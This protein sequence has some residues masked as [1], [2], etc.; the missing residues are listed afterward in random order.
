MSN[1]KQQGVKAFTWDF[2]GKLLSQGMGFIVTIFLARLLEPEDFGLVA[3]IMV[4]IGIANIFTDIGLGGALIQRRRVHPIHYSSVFYFNIIVGF[5][6][7][8]VTYL[9]AEWIGEF[10]QN[11]QLVVLVQVLS[12]LF[13]INA[14]SS[15]QNTRLR[16]E[17]NYSRLTKMSFISSLISGFVGIYLAMDGA[18][19]WSLVG[20][21]LTMTVVYNVL[22]WTITDWRPSLRFSWKAL[23][24]L[25][26]YG[27]RMFLSGM[28]DV[29]F[30]KI[31]FLIIGK[32]FPLAT[33]GYFQRAKSLNR[34][35]VQ[36]SSGSLMAVLFPVFSK[37]QNDVPRFQNII[38]KSL[39]IISFV[40]F[41]LI[42]VLFLISEELIVI[43][44]SAKWLPS[45][46]FFKVLV[47]SGFAYPISAL[48]VNILS[49]RGKSKEFLRLEIYKKL[50]ASCNLLILFFLG[51]NAF[52]YG[53]IVQGVLG[54]LL[55]IVFASREI[56]LQYKV[57]I[58]P[59]LVQL[60]ISVLAV[61]LTISIV[62]NL[63][64][65]SLF[66]L[67]IK[68]S[69]FTVLYFLL[70]YLMKTTSYG[71]FMGELKSIFSER[72]KYQKEN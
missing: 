67:L 23:R 61:I 21:I 46:D 33:L 13:V 65:I 63:E 60:S 29:I 24:Q 55:N 70:S 14:L 51:I 22:I 48:L 2:F 20:Q 6:L 26:G 5:F 3:L 69:V 11:K 47:L 25:W 1:L 9:S 44:F 28:L 32:I 57:F 10:Y 64:L 52:L 72:V 66:M 54:V 71:Y 27:F 40:V 58:K 68:G 31:D 53:L 42:G 16:K 62:D 12:S 50:I 37:V 49:S 35:V 34:M 59:I 36:Y 19:V 39:G 45:V 4:I 17:L 30:T 15:V 18:G 41:L 7:T 8:I 43:I 38:L 56:K